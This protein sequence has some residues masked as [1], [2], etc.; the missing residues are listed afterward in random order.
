MRDHM[1][2]IFYNPQD[3]L[4][5]PGLQLFDKPGIFAKGNVMC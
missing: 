2:I 4:F 1:K 5:D 3:G